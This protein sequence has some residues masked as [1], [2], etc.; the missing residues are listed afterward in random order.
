MA[1]PTVARAPQIPQVSQGLLGL[2]GGRFDPVHRMHLHMA[3]AAADQLGLQEL[4]WL[5]TGTPVHKPAMAPAEARLAMVALALDALG[6]ARMVVDDREVRAAAQ[7]ESNATHT[8]IARLREELGA[9]PL[10][11]ILGEDQLEHF[12]EWQRWDW[13]LTQMDIAVCARP[14]SSDCAIRQALREAGAR[15][16]RV[17]V[18]PSSLSSTQLRDAMAEGTPPR[19]LVP[20]LPAAVADYLAHRPYYSQ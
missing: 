2:F 6:D 9:R 15:I 3:T 1:P 5:V 7:G 10:V 16:H 13:L 11:W 19:A 18:S 12:T 4:R 17:E 20:D 8:T 14:G